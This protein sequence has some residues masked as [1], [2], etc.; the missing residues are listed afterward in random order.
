MLSPGSCPASSSSRFLIAAPAGAAFAAA[1]FAAAAFG[2]PAHLKL[3]P[4]PTPLYTTPL[5][6]HGIPPARAT[7]SSTASP[8][9]PFPSPLPPPL[10]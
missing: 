3:Y 9:S 1:A 5:S 8:P 6:E 7:P 4:N 2:D 10:S